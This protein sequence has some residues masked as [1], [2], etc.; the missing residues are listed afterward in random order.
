LRERESV[1][2]VRGK[3]VSFEELN[4]LKLEIRV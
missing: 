4:D 3:K 1:D 2:V